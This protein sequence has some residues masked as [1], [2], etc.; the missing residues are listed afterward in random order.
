[1]LL[2]ISHTLRGLAGRQ[3]SSARL[4]EACLEAIA[5]PSGEGS[6]A[7]IRIFPES[8]R[9]TA[10][11]LDARRTQGPLAGLPISIK[12]LFDVRGVQTTGGSVA[13]AEAPAA[14]K[15]AAI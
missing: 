12:D 13:L 15:D 6:R 10:A 4:V 2:P 14:K 3:L 7:F 5:N 1:M 9:S 8:A 11:N